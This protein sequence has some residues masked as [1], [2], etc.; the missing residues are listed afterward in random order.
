MSKVVPLAHALPYW[1]VGD[2]CVVLTDG[3]LVLP[4]RLETVSVVT[5]TDDE[6]NAL[7][8]LFRSTLNSCPPGFQLQIL[9][10][11]RKVDGR[12]FHAYRAALKSPDPILQEQRSAGAA[13]LR[14]LNMRV[15]DTWLF[16]S[17]PKALNTSSGQQDMVSR[18]LDFISGGG[19][20]AQI[21]R[22]RHTETLQKLRQQA[23]LF[24]QSLGSVGLRCTPLSDEEFVQLAYAFLNPGREGYTRLEDSRP[25]RVLPEK[26][27]PLYR[28]LSLREQLVHCDC[29]QTMDTL[30][31]G[32]PLQPHRILALKAMPRTTEA[33][34]IRKANRI[35]F[36]HWLSVGLS[37]PDSEAQFDQVDKR[38][39]RA[40]AWA[41]GA[42]R[43]IKAEEQADELEAALRHMESNDQR[44]FN[45]SCQL[46]IPA[47]DVVELENRTTQALA[48][49][50]DFHTPLVT[51]RMVQLPAFV[52]M[53]PGAAH[54][55]PEARTVLTDNAAHMLPV[56]DAWKGDAEPVWLASTRNGEPLSIDLRDP[57]SDAWNFNV[58]GRTGSGKSFFIL[59]QLTSAMLGQGSPVVVIDVGG[60]QD[61]SYYRLC[62]LLGGDFVDLSLD[63]ANAINPFPS[64]ADLFSTDT[65]ET[66]ADAN[67][68]K[69][70]LLLALATL[71]CN[72]PGVTTRT[73]IGERIL[74]D[75]ILLTYR[76]LGRGLPPLFSDLA[77]TLAH[78]YRGED[79]E[80]LQLAQRYAKTLRS[81]LA[82]AAGKLL[83]QQTKVRLGSSF[84]VFDL[85]GLEQLG[86]VATAMLYVVNAY[87]WNMIGRPGRRELA[88]VIYDET[89]KLM[90]HP[91]AAEL[92]EELYRTARKLRAGV[93]SV[94]Q[95]LE[96]FLASAASKAVLSN[97]IRT[98]LLRHKDNHDAVADLVD[99][100]AVELELFRSLTTKK[101]FFS[102]VLMKTD[103]H[104]SVVRF[105]PSPWDY[106]VNTTDGADKE[107]ERSLLPQFGGDRLATLRHLV[108]TYP[109]GAAAGSKK[110]SHAA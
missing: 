45:L 91:T 100:N 76:R 2:G 105:S 86:D 59:S 96:D 108:A 32:E 47:A 55:A 39:K 82:G 85:K 80:D 60:G 74:R 4:F 107:L 75:A 30:F 16:F 103:T 20:A 50:T 56:Y 98:F 104:S 5:S 18:I 11:S 95:K 67:E 9:R 73:R 88:W 77:E 25:P 52:G 33:A 34:M 70:T 49:F 6:V 1:W 12:L 61:G 64:H 110:V 13:H 58:F 8:D 99:L 35:P 66:S 29:S 36:D 84:I 7:A 31:L 62:K 10:R 46:L 21:T 48:A 40:R 17:W 83:N 63:G 41:A 15:F 51:A 79:S 69:L 26:E 71:A 87:V 22:E 109:N 44:V 106:W 78:H 28:S 43:N 23:Q 37:V 72:D 3:T 68:G 94:T 19:R 92:Q 53:A 42:V 97:T 101:G 54:L 27:R 89:W 57:K 102:E 65:G 14:R 90:R 24:L 38:R 93:V 81:F